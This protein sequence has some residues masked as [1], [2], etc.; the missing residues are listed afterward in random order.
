MGKAA[1]FDNWFYIEDGNVNN[2]V[3]GGAG[4]AG[5]AV[6]GGTPTGGTGGGH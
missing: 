6:G 4:G 1:F 3:T 2:Y 5:G